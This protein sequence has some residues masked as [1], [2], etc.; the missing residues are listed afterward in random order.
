[1]PH[2][3]LKLLRNW[4]ER[5]SLK[6]FVVTSNVDGQFQKAGFAE[7]EILEV[8]GSIDHLQCTVPCC[9]DI[10]GND[11]KVDIAT[12]QAQCFPHC[13]HC[14]FVARP[15]ILMFGDSSW[16][17]ARAVR[18]RRHFDRFL[19]NVELPLLVIEVGAGKAIPTIRHLSERLAH[20]DGNRLIRINPREAQVPERQISL[21]VGALEGLEQIEAAL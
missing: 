10:W 6:S 4:I 20:P 15:N 21:A 16:L 8:H 5:Y 2:R 18:Q 3:G 9:D 14:R 12:L 19:A 1:M 13:I 11:Q 7:E 17:N